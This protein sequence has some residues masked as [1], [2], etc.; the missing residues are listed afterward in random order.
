[1]HI[2]DEQL[3]SSGKEPIFEIPVIDKRTGFEDWIICEIAV[4]DNQLKAYRVAVTEQEEKSNKI[5][6][7]AIDID[8]DFSLDS[9]LQ[10]LYGAVIDSILSSDF[11]ELLD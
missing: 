6:F 8:L 11:Y 7:N 5:A 9:H 4:R 2:F 10:E 3:S 1:M